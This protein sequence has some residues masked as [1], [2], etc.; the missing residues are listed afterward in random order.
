MAGHLADETEN[1]NADGNNPDGSH[2]RKEVNIGICADD[3]G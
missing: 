1:R 3:P 2:K